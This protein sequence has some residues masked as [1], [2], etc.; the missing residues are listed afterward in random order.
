MSQSKNFFK[1]NYRVE[2][3]APSVMRYPR[4]RA[5]RPRNPGVYG[6]RSFLKVRVA[7]EKL[8]T[9][10]ERWGVAGSE[11]NLGRDRPSTTT[12]FFGHRGKITQYYFWRQMVP[13]MSL[14]KSW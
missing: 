11:R 9:I 2:T 3:L 7:R 6:R 8:P 12:Y 10:D 1:L 4:I 14:V 13:V 5:D